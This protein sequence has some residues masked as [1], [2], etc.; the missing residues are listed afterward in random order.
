MP[1]PPMPPL[2]MPETPTPPMPSMRPYRD[3]PAPLSILDLSISNALR[4]ITSLV[5]LILDCMIILWSFSSCDSISVK[6]RTCDMVTFS[7]WPSAMTS[8]KAKMRSK[9]ARLMPSSSVCCCVYSGRT[10]PRSRRMSRS[11]RMLDALLVT[12]RRYS[13]PCSMGVYTYRTFSVST[14]VCWVPVLTSLG[15]AA[16]SPSMRMRVIGTYWRDTRA[17]PPLVTTEAARTTIA[18][19]G[20]SSLPITPGAAPQP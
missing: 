2:P 9:A 8:S 1:P 19:F 14:Y 7:L 3:P 11:S 15:N 5:S 16:S 10:L 20:Y 13:C 18:S 4:F 12:R 17:L 6:V